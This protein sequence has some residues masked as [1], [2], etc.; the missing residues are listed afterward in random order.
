LLPGLEVKISDDGEILTRGPHV[1][2]GY[3]RDPERTEEAI[4]EEGWLHTGDVGEMTSDG[5]LRLTD[6]K[7]DLFKLST[8]KYVMPQPLESRLTT[9][10]LVEQVIV[11]GEDYRFCT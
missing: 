9:E 5:F 7:K 4:D 1:M 8:G 11:I 3:F 6:R 2:K 10:P